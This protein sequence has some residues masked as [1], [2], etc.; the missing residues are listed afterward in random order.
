MRVVTGATGF[1]GREIVRS[2]LRHGAEPVRCLV[3]P[4]TPA[5]R[6]AAL[7]GAG[8]AG[9]VEAVP[10][11]LDD[12]V[13]LARALAGAH[14][15]YHAAAVKRGAPAAL[16]AGTVVPTEHLLHAARAAAVERVVLISSF[17]VMG[18]AGLGRGG[19]V[20]EE[21]P[22]DPRPEDR[23]A[24]VFAKHRQEALA[25][26]LA[27]ELRLPLAVVRPGMIFGPGQELLG[28]R[29]GLALGPLFLAL[30]GRATLPLTYVENCADAVVLAGT[31]PGAAGRALC[32]VDDDLPSARA[33]LSRYRREVARV[34]AVPVPYPLLL[35]LARLNAW[36]STRTAG[37]LPAVLTPYKVR[38]LWRPQRYSNRRARAVLGWSPRV[39]MAEALDRTLRALATRPAARAPVRL[40][41]APAAV[42]PAAVAPSAEARA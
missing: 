20:D 9:R 17:S 39:P 38:S 3:R 11:R 23:D 30:G 4:G 41:G 10:V 33:V 8:A 14:V 28:S 18:V 27:E 34:A 6:L 15:V 12:R 2:L 1:L 35:L 13:A 19:L 37:H 5:E 26:R 40:P 31:A 36:Y 22:L 16:V 25:W 42:T 21:A 29:L 7:S 24:Y 32:V